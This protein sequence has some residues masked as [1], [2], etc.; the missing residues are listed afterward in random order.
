MKKILFA[1]FIIA[2]CSLLSPHCYLSVYAQEKVAEFPFPAGEE[3]LFWGEEEKIITATKY[4]KRLREA[5]AIATVITSEQIRNMGAKNLRDV[6]KTVPGIGISIVTG[7]GKYG[8]ESRGIKSIDTEKILVMIDGHRVN[9]T[10]S[11]GAMWVFDD[12]F[13]E[14]IKRVEV[15]KG[16]GSALHGANAFVAV[17]NVITKDVGDI[18]GVDVRAGGGSFS[19]QH[20]D[21]LFGKEYSKFKIAGNFDYLDSKGAKLNIESDRLKKSGQTDDWKKRYDLGLKM[22]YGD[23]SFNGKYVN[24]ERGP[25]IGVANAL[26]DE[27]KIETGHLFG[28]LIYKHSLREDLHLMLKGY[29]DNYYWKANWEISPEGALSGFPDGFIGIPELKNRTYGSE[30]QVDYSLWDGNKLTGGVLY[31][32]IKQYDVKHN[33]NFNPLTFA[34]LGSIQDVS[35]YGNWNQNKDRYVSAIYLQDVWKF[36]ADIEGTIGVRYDNYSDFGNTTNPRLGLVWNF[37]EGANLKLLYGSAFRA[38]NFKELYNINNPAELGSTD[39]KPEKLRTYEASI[40]YN[41]LGKYTTNLTYFNSEI[42]DI[43]QIENK[44]FKNSGKA[45]VEGI[46]AELKINYRGSSYSYINYTYQNPWDVSGGS[47]LPDVAAQ[48]GNIGFNMELGRYVNANANLL[49]VRARPRISADTRS[50]LSGYETLD[51]T[52]IGKNFYKDAEIRGSAYNLLNKTYADPENTGALKNDFPR[53]GITFMVEAS[54]GF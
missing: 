28:E 4:I 34:P 45:K 19:T 10:M 33:A 16:P 3:A 42:E 35:S 12:M 32:D 31:E 51:L 18:D 15:I 36:T 40:V 53:Q 37:L 23:I 5:P 43:I 14:N 20:Y 17:I 26:N 6:L 30:I 9:D 25:Y 44:K 47:R 1:L 46:E 38:P 7:Y 50:E 29:Y 39:L 54:Y 24:K 41:F 22:S 48:K 27:S 2:H 13:V 11:G 49:V 8:I 52:L 21:L